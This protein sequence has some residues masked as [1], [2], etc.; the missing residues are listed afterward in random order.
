[1]GRARRQGLC[2]IRIHQLRDFVQDK[3]RRVDDSPYGGGPGQVMLC[4]PL[5]AAV[6]ALR[7]PTTKVLLMGPAGDQFRQADARALSRE[8]HLIFICGH[9]EGIDARVRQALVDRELSIG[10]YVLTSGN[11]AAMVIT[12]ACVRLLPGALGCDQ[13][14]VSESFSHEDYLEHPQYTRPENFRGMSVPEVLL[15]GNHR[16]IEKWRKEQSHQRLRETRPDLI[17]KESK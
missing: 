11:L 16:E 6:E 15:S 14:A 8:E 9:Y 5:F 3:H 4:E 12:D 2:E 7:T 10:D 1:V 13:S 17:K